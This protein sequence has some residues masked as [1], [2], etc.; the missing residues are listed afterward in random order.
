MDTGPI[1]ILA[2]DQKCCYYQSSIQYIA[3]IITTILHHNRDTTY[4]M[5]TFEQSGSLE[6]MPPCRYATSLQE[7]AQIG[8]LSQSL[9]SISEDLNDLNS[10]VL[11]Q[12]SL[13]DLS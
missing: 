8:K 7:P 2:N 1:I 6:L 3:R 4:K 9:H 11:S 10:P 5:Q 12:I 13:S